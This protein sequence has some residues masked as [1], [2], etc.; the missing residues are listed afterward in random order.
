MTKK[1][2]KKK[3]TKETLIIVSV[4]LFERRNCN[5]DVCIGKQNTNTE[6]MSM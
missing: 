4:D 5:F 6:A 3:S 2:K 1:K